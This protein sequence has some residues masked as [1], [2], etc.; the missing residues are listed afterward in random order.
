M[1]GLPYTFR[2]DDHRLIIEL[3]EVIDSDNSGP[4]EDGLCALLP[5]PGA[6]CVVVDIHVAVVTAANLHLLLRLRQVVERNGMLLFVVARQPSARKVFRITH[7]ERTL[8]V[9]ASLSRARGAT[10]RPAGDRHSTPGG[11]AGPARPGTP[12]IGYLHK[13]LHSLVGRIFNRLG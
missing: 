6:A 2:L 8:R 10:R 13:L 1:S 9:T 7:L 5:H 11:A 3:H 4:V 12:P